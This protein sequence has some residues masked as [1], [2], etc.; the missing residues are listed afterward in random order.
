MQVESL[1]DSPLFIEATPMTMKEI[2]MKLLSEQSQ[3]RFYQRLAG[4]TLFFCSHR[5]ESGI[6]MAN[7]AGVAKNIY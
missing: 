5:N 6:F 1:S 7:I 2:I 3:P 4:K